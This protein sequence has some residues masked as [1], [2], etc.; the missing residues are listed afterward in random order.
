[1][2]QTSTSD[3]AVSNESLD[4][5]MLAMDVVDT[6]RHEHIM[7]EKDLASENRRKNLIER[8]RGIYKAQGIEVPDSVL[9]DGVL[10]LEEQRLIFMSIVANGSLLS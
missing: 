9:M 8:L 1:L 2:T 5:I 4:D 10:A 7:V 3:A 6:L